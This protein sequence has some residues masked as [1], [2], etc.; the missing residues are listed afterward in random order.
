VKK[1]HSEPVF[2]LI[3]EQRQ[4]FQEKYH[5]QSISELT[6]EEFEKVKQR[7]KKGYQEWKRK[8]AGELDTRR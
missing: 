5:P 4:R 7:V 6:D 3:E 1:I 8:I 2:D